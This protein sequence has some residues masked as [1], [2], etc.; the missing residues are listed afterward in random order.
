[1]QYLSDDIGWLQLPNGAYVLG[2][3]TVVVSLAAVKD[4]V[5]MTWLGYTHSSHSH[6]KT[7]RNVSIATQ[8]VWLGET[9]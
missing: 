1:M 9:T 5:L 6:T 4:I 8:W 7:N 3:G 2:Y